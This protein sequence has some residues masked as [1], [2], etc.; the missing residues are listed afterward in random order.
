VL[1]NLAVL[2]ATII[3]RLDYSKCLAKHALDKSSSK[4]LQKNFAE[5]IMWCNLVLYTKLLCSRSAQNNKTRIPS[6]TC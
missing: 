3:S 4:T 1:E 2:Q 6:I 5:N